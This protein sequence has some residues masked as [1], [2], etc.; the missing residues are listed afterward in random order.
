MAVAGAA[1]LGIRSSGAQDAKALGMELS[2]Q[3]LAAGAA[4]LER[5]ASV[6]IHSHP[7]RFFL[8]QLSFETPTTRAFGEAFEERAVADL[9]AGN[10]SAA[11]FSA[12]ADVRLL[13]LTATQGLRAARDFQ[14]GEA[15]ADYGRQLAELKAL[16]ANHAL[17]KGL[18]PDDIGA[19]HRRRK[20]AAV[21]AVEGGDFI[22]QR[23]DRVHEAFRDGVRA[24][25]LVHYHINQIGD[26]QTEAPVHQGLTALGKSV[27]AEM[28][29]TGI[30]IDLA[31][32][33]FEVT[34]DVLEVSTKPIM[35]SHTNL[36]TRTV[37]HPRLISSEHA[38]LVA[39]AGGI[40]GSWPSG[41][42]Q[43]SFADYIDSIQRL[44]D[45]V[46]IDHV[47]IGTDMDANFKPVLRS[48]RDWSHIPAALLARGVPDEDVAKIMGGN[49]LRLFK[50][51]Q[52][53]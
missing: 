27:V 16:A 29:Q 21:F 6:D 17:T 12:V 22:E 39:A 45:A 24:I 10:V 52:T 7:G 19:A 48:Y 35:I 13:E 44:I 36:A 41:V 18:G 49:F 51:N 43:T 47:A 33:T 42:G 3:Q 15:Y 26:I 11:L 53:R 40:I 20:T 28:N 50:S 5:H 37:N 23:L 2:P 9:G 8:K 14:P 32:A 38:K 1:A 4:F 46:G 30:I 25:T 34:K 31:H